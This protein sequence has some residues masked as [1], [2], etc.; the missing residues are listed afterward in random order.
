MNKFDRIVESILEANKAIDDKQMKKIKGIVDKYK[1][2]GADTIDSMVANTNQNLSNK[3]IA[4]AYTDLG[5][6]DDMKNTES[7]KR[8]RVRRRKGYFS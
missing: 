8:S 4:Q 6:Y 7:V 3:Q 2:K 1:G 5:I